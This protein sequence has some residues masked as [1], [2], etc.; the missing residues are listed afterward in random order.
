MLLLLAAAELIGSGALDPA[1]RLSRAAVEPVAD[2]GLWQHLRQGEMSV[3]DLAVLVGSVS[4]NL[5]TNVLLERVGL[6]AVEDVRSELGLVRTRLLDRVRDVRAG[7]DPPALSVGSASELCGLI[8][9]LRSADGRWADSGQMVFGWLRLGCDLSMVASAFHLD[10]LARVAPAGGGG[11]LCLVNKT[12]TNLGVRGDVGFAEGP[13][14]SATYAVVANW[15]AP[16][17]LDQVMSGMRG[18]GEK[19]RLAIS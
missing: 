17:R 13:G 8:D 1:E 14:G 5:A 2:S 10:P 16:G 4:D 19:I 12:G 7:D 11:E 6:D 15:Q 3:G 9:Q 18:I